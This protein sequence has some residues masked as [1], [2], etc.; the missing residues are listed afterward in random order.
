ME[1]RFT[2]DRLAV[3]PWT[4]PLPSSEA[5]EISSILDEDVT[6]F[7]PESLL[8]KRGETDAKEWADTFSSG[9]NKVSSVRYGDDSELAGLLLLRPES[10]SV[11]HL[12]YIFGKKYWG[13]GLATELL[14]GLVKQLDSDE[15][16]GQVH[17]GVV[18]GNPASVAVLKKVDFETM[19]ESD[20][21]AD[22][23]DWFIR[24]FGRD[25]YF[26]DRS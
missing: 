14:R 21:G 17:A 3:Q 19:K 6:A 25:K 12:G 7:L 16:S 26:E 4:L 15:F 8:Y 1:G 10:D 24:H 18:K 22:D 2:T 20:S 5:T 11:V 23:V 9:S 13:K